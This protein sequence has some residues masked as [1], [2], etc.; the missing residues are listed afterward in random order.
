MLRARLGPE[1]PVL[2]RIMTPPGIA[3]EH[4]DWIV[5]RV[6]VPGLQPLHGNHAF[7]HLGGPLWKAP[8]P[9]WISTLPHPF[10]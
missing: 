8:T 3:Q 4:P 10:A 5:V 2:F 7:P 9:D 6:V 1:R